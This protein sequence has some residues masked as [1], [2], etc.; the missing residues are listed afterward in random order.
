[1]NVQT[2]QREQWVP[3]PPATTFKLFSDAFTLERITPP[4]LRFRVDA[5]GPIEIAEGP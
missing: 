4:W 1:M 5:P 3:T 2:L